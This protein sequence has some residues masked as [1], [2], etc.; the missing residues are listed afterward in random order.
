MKEITY[1]STAAGRYESAMAEVTAHFVPFLLH[2]ARIDLGNRVLDIA[3]GTGIAA[4]AALLRVG[5][6]GHVTAADASASMVQLAQRRLGGAANVEVCVT[7]GQVMGFRD[8]SFDAVICSLG[9]MFFSDPDRGLAEFYRV[10]RPG[11]HVAASVLTVPERSYNGRINVVAARYRP[12]LRD[13]IERTFRLGSAP[14]LRSM[15]ATAGF[16]GIETT[17]EHRDFV[18]P[19]FAD[20]YD[21]FEA[22]GA[23]TG[24]VL[25]ELPET[26]RRAVREEVRRSLMDDGGPVIVPVE[27]LIARAT[28][29]ST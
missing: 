13:A 5:S 10:L 7:D 14:R 20:Y 9:L 16:G 8:A 21:P 4:H 17:L 29:P 27:L 22:G 26:A 1:D 6:A 25:K 11:G 28:K 12:E 15:F 2:A 23:S 24:D 18:L 19:S 3:T